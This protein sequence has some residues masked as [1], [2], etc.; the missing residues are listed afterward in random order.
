MA[1]DYP[2]RH[3][4]T[5]GTV[6]LPCVTSANYT[7]RFQNLSLSTE[8]LLLPVAIPSTLAF[9][10]QSDRPDVIVIAEGGAFL[11]ENSRRRD[12]KQVFAEIPTLLLATHAAAAVLRDARRSGIHSVIPLQVTAHQLVTAIAATLEGFAVTLPRASATSSVALQIAE[13]LDASGEAG[14]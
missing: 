5:Q 1:E 7:S 9:R 14:E 4:R 3:R 10:V 2:S 13:E 6:I 12:L 8:F 11:A